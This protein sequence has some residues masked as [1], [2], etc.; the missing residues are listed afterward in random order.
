MSLT[1]YELLISGGWRLDLEHP[2]CAADL[3]AFTGRHGV[4]EYLSG[5]ELHVAIRRV[6]TQ[7]DR[8]RKRQRSDLRVP[9]AKSGWISTA[10]DVPNPFVLH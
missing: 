5:G 2:P 1:T 6:Q 7:R 10:A 8:T 3:K 4:G 9:P